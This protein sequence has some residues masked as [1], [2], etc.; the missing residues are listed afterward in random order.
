[1]QN[2]KKEFRTNKLKTYILLSKLNLY[3]ASMIEKLGTRTFQAVKG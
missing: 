2:P 1:M 3:Y